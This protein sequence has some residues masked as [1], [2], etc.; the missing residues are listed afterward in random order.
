MG[1]LATQLKEMEQEAK[2]VAQDTKQ[3][4]GSV[5]QDEQLEQLTT[6][7]QE[8]EGQLETLKTLLRALPP[9]VQITKFAE[10]KEL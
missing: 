10:L 9:V 6:Q 2:K 5:V 4:C 7:L 1:D 8:V 3:F